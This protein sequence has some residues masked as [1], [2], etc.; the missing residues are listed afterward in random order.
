MPLTR[1]QLLDPAVQQRHPQLGVVHVCD[2]VTRHQTSQDTTHIRHAGSSS[3]IIPPPTRR[4]TH[5]CVTGA[6]FSQ[7]RRTVGTATAVC[8]NWRSAQS[9]LRSG[10]AGR[11]LPVTH[12]YS[13]AV[14]ASA[15]LF[16]MRA[17]HACRSRRSA[18]ALAASVD[19]W[20]GDIASAV[21]VEDDAV[22]PP[23]VRGAA[24]VARALP[25]V[26]PSSWSVHS[27]GLVGVALAPPT[28]VCLTDRS[29]KAG[30]GT[31]TNANP[32]YSS[33]H[34]LRAH[35]AALRG[36]HSHV[37]NDT[38]QYYTSRP[39]TWHCASSAVTHQ[40]H[41]QVGNSNEC[42]LGV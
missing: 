2:S 36:A 21:V 12:P 39:H 35:G 25:A 22:V 27:S 13:A 20:G 26:S 1:K 37:H 19:T 34:D 28:G 24:S 7:K 9:L 23:D 6:V 15:F 4:S 10:Y 5:N 17:R 30:L 3:R 29:S 42:C 16:C 41:V 8:R 33:H 14:S 32:T 40:R 38:N 11:E 31:C 18:A